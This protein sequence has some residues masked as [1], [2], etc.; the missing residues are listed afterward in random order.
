M[1]Y[2]E[3]NSYNNRGSS[4][5]KLN[6]NQEALADYKKA[7]SNSS[8]S[9]NE[10]KALYYSNCGLSYYN[11]KKKT[12]ACSMFRKSLYFSNTYARYYNYYCK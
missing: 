6:K 1:K 9:T 10:D 7:I 8:G 5:S 2:A 12:E 4:Y 3:A 11:L